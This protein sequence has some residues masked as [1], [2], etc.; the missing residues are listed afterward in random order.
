MATRT[1]SGIWRAPIF[2]PESSRRLRQHECPTAA[3]L[4]TA[5]RRA[6]AS[7]NASSIFS[8][9]SCKSGEI[10]GMPSGKREMA[11]VRFKR[12]VKKFGAFTAVSDLN[13]EVVDKEFLV[14]LG[15]SGC[16]KTTTMRMVAGLEEVTAGDILIAEERVNDVLPKYR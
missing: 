5:G 12:V 2:S 3:R 10:L 9:A 6:V 7:F 14:L 4:A 13:L 8:P 15:P 11:S 16:G 1:G